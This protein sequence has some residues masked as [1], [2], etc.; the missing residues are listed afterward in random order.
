MHSYIPPAGSV[1][2]QQ[3]SPA[4]TLP[5][6]LP[7]SPCYSSSC[8]RKAALFYHKGPQRKKTALQ[9]SVSDEGGPGMTLVTSFIGTHKLLQQVWDTEQVSTEDV[10]K[11]EHGSFQKGNFYIFIFLSPWGCLQ[12]C[13]RTHV[14]SGTTNPLLA[15][16][17]A[18]NLSLL[19]SQAL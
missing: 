1:A 15:W 13:R 10:G 18:A 6:C 16:S 19:T 8:S 5:W 11:L 12:M 3:G 14:P 17:R 4:L 7:K 2:Q 9:Q